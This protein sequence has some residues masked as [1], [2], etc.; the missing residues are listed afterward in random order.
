MMCLPGAAYGSGL[1]AA[2]PDP[3]RVLLRSVAPGDVP[4]LAGR[5]HLR[6]STQCQ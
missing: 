2:A 5:E 1:I 3:T 4:R 6:L